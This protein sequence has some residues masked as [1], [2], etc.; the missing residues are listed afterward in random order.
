MYIKLV[1]AFRE[2][3]AAAILKLSAEIGHYLA[4]AHVPLHACSNHNGQYTGQRGI[5]GFWESR[6]P[7]LL[8]EREWDFFLGPAD[9]ISHTAAYAWQV[10]KESAAASDTVLRYEKL[11]TAQFPPDRKYAFE[12]RNGVLVRQY[13]IDFSLAYDRMLGGMVERRMRASV[14]A[15]ASF[16]YSAW[17]DAGQP[18]L[19]PLSDKVFSE[20]D[21]KEFESL[22]QSWKNNS[23][24]G[25]E[26]E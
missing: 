24:Y 9:Y 6:I 4:D 7:E 22:E 3:Q 1:K 26:E 18:D 20:K 13:S 11:L 25:R 8:A 23:L 17:V 21:Q 10:V 2:K 14:H 16:W 5:H 12:L 15:V 19:S